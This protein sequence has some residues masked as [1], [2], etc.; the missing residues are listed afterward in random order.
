VLIIGTGLSMADVVVSLRLTGH[1]GPITA[2]SRRGLTP[3]ARTGLPVEAFGSFDQPATDSAAR[4]LHNIRRAAHTA[5]QHGRPWEG[6]IDSLRKQ[7]TAVWQGLSPASRRRLLRHARAWW[8]VHRYQI[9]PQLDGVLVADR[10][11]G[12]LKIVKADVLKIEA[13]EEAFR[14]ALRLRG[15][16]ENPQIEQVFDA[17]VN[18]TGPDQGAVVQAN[19]LLRAMAA[20][21]LLR[22]DPL[23]LGIEVDRFARVLGGNDQPSPRLFVAGPLARGY[24]GDLMSLPEVSLQPERLAHTIAAL[25]ARDDLDVAV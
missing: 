3:R 25:L 13:A 20:G 14:V 16:H 24:F 9:A 21:G 4:L 8:D 6:V 1:T 22:A 23:G 19:P 10:Q 17:V 18:C 12:R 5:A 7:G 2:V 11:S 15:K